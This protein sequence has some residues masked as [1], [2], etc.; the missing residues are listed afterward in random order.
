M[1]LSKLF[2]SAKIPVIAAIVVAVIAVAFNLFSFNNPAIDFDLSYNISNVLSAIIVLLVIWSGYSLAKTDGKLIDTAIFGAIIGA[3]LAVIYTIGNEMVYSKQAE[4][5]ADMPYS[6]ELG[7]FIAS[8]V[9]YIV[10][11]AVLGAIAIVI[12][13]FIEKNLN[14]K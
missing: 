7:G 5:F 2:S 6:F 8:L 10:V 4:L 14:K 12:G 1:D 11:F 3:V 13:S 9:L